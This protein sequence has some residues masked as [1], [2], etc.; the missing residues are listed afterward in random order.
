MSRRPAS[1]SSQG[2]NCTTSAGTPARRQCST[3]SRPTRRVCGAGL[4]ITALPAAS[5][6]STPPA[7]MAY[8]KFHG[9]AT[10]V[11][12]YGSKC[13]PCAC[14]LV[15]EVDAVTRSSGRSRWPRTPRCRP[16]LTVL[17]AVWAIAAIGR[18][19]RLAHLVGDP[20][21]DG[22]AL[23]RWAGAPPVG[24]GQR[25]GPRRRRRRSTVGRADVVGIGA[26]QCAS[27][28][29]IQRRLTALVKSVSGSLENGAAGCVTV[30]ARR[31]GVAALGSM[32][33]QTASSSTARR[34]RAFSVSNALDPGSIANSE[35]RKFS[36]AAFSSRRRAR[37][38]TA[39]SSSSCLVGGAVQQQRRRR[40]RRPRPWPAAA[41]CLRA[42]RSRRDP[43]RGGGRRS[44]SAHATSN[45]L[46]DATPTRTASAYLRDERNV[47]HALVVGVDIGL[48][49]ERRRA[50]SRAARR[51]R[52]PSRGWRP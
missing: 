47:E 40:R 52:S 19:A 37:Y 14:D 45:R 39:D 27:A 50:S 36:G 16:R 42:S 7:G 3:T 43:P 34:K 48:V 15:D 22:G 46:C 20:P 24:R 12:R 6:A 23:V 2:T 25:R 21:Q 11:T 33:R 13:A 44:V 4:R 26:R 17:P 35:C 10:T 1:S 28:S 49:V 8:G 31:R 38:A 41:P 32:R 30:G 5:A 29:V 18:P 9:D 51:R